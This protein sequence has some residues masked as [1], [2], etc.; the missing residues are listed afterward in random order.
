[1]PRLE[2]DT[3]VL[4]VRLTRS[5]RDRLRHFAKTLGKDMAT[6]AQLAIEDRLEFLEE[7]EK[8]DSLK[9]KSQLASMPEHVKPRGLGTAPSTKP[10][11]ATAKSSTLPSPF[12]AL[13]SPQFEVPEK[14]KRAF[15]NWAE[16]VEEADGIVDTQRRTKMIVEDIKQRVEEKDVQPCYEAFVDFLT[17]RKDA[18]EPPSFQVDVPLVGDV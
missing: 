7:K 13:K 4:K 11:T 6:I 17:A 18:K 15:K 3:I 8:Q 5:H 1:M 9:K 14:V 16:Y 12:D 2:K 10:S